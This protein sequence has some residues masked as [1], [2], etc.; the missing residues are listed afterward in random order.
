[1]IHYI[2]SAIVWL[3]SFHSPEIVKK[4]A[5]LI[6][7]EAKWYK[8]HP[9]LVV[10]IIHIESKWKKNKKSITNDYGL[11]Q[12]HVARNGSERFLGRE[13]ELFDPRT[14]IREGV[15]ILAMWRKYHKTYCKDSSHPFWAHYKWGKKV[16]EDISHALKVEAI[17]H[18]LLNRFG[19]S[20]LT[21]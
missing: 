13:K 12:V 11:M 20:W 9:F 10:S 14:N 4:Y 18:I 17:F 19:N 15:R 6:A 7:F 3:S 1:M 8:V 2:A 5:D 16:K 21:S